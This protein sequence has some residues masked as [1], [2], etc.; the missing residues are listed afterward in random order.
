MSESL[1]CCVIFHCSHRGKYVYMRHEKNCHTTWT[2]RSRR[3]I[4]PSQRQILVAGL[5]WKT[6]RI[7]NIPLLSSDMLYATGG[8]NFG[9]VERGVHFIVAGRRSLAPQ[10]QNCRD[11]Q[12]CCVSFQQFPAATASHGALSRN[13]R[14][15][16]S[17][18]PVLL[19]G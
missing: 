9:D 19:N 14:G 4:G 10:S 17:N 1:A 15:Y 5:P 8:G 3:T 18:T 11:L 16:R 6:E 12:T 7:L 13:W 2:C